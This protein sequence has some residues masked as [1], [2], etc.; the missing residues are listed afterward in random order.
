MAR[1]KKD[2]IDAVVDGFTA[3][4]SAQQAIAL[5]IIRRLTPTMEQVAAV[6]RPRKPKVQP[7][8]LGE[9]A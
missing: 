3:L 7:Q 1:K 2:P 5:A 6:V 4:D 8:A 9:T